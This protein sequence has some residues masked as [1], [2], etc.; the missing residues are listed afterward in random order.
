MQWLLSEKCVP[1]QPFTQPV[2][3]KACWVQSTGD[4]NSGRPG[5]LRR[6]RHRCSTYSQ[7]NKYL[8]TN[9]SR[10]AGETLSVC[11]RVCVQKNFTRM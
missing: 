5:R 1:V 4:G 10:A 11:V 9:C 3:T 6:R 8:S 7:T 2:R